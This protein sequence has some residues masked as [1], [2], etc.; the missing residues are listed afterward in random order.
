MNG[1][2]SAKMLLLVLALMI[3]VVPV[4]TAA[5]PASP[6]SSSQ[7]D[8]RSIEVASAP[9]GPRTHLG[10]LPAEAQTAISAAIGHH[11]P[12]YQFTKIGERY[13]GAN[14]AHNLAMEFRAGGVEVRVGNARWGL[15]LSALGYGDALHTLRAT[16]PKATANRVEYRYGEIAEWYV[17]GPLGLEQGF[18][19]AQAESMP[20]L[21][22]LREAI[23]G[24]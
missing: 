21:V 17:N 8:S 5:G 9:N 22:D 24:S 7:D 4:C 14:T 10:D 1:G 20:I 11:D 16:D 23:S 15:R 3:C 12:I 2:C 13:R 19:I 6:V 18:T